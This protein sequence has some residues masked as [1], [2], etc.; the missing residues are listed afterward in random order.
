MF[1]EINAKEEGRFICITTDNEFHRI[2]F[3][4]DYSINGVIE[5]IK[6]VNKCTK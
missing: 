3:I 2:L 5:K 4:E 1:W 6:A